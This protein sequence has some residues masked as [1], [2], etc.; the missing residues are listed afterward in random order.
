M[1]VHADVDVPVHA[2]LVRQL[3][4]QADGRRAALLRAAV[5]GLHQAGTAARD[6][7]HPVLAQLAGDGARQLVLGIGL[8]HARRSEDRDGAAQVGE[9]AEAALELVVDPLEAAHVVL[10]RGDAR[11]L[12]LDDLLVRGL[13]LARLAHVPRA[14]YFAARFSPRDSK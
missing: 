10:V 5:R 8:G 4:V 2:L 9:Q 3:D 14:T 11:R 13:R 1:A 6:D 12:G 7:G